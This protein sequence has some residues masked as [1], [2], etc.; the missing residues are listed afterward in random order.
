MAMFSVVCVLQQS[1]YNAPSVHSA[2]PHRSHTHRAHSLPARPVR[3]TGIKTH[4]IPCECS[5]V[6][7]TLGALARRSCACTA[8]HNTSRCPKIPPIAPGEFPDALHIP[9]LLPYLWPRTARA[10]VLSTRLYLEL[11]L[12]RR[13]ALWTRSLREHGVQDC[14]HGRPYARPLRMELCSASRRARGGRA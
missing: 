11:P 9:H 13:P 8:R 7:R 12:W 1:S 4:L 6:R 3:C 2:P 5:L 14:D 10:V